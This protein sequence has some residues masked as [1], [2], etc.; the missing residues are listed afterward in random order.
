ML[1]SVRIPAADT[2]QVTGLIDPAEVVVQVDAVVLVAGAVGED[3]GGMILGQ[4]LHG[5]HVVE[6]GAENDVAAFLDAL[7]DGG[8]GFGDVLVGNVDLVDDLIVTQARLVFIC[9]M[10]WSWA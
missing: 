5:V 6:A 7:L 3:D 4:L 10:P 9:W 8:A 2:R 1:D